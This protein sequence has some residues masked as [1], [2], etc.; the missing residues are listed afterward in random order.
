MRHCTAFLLLLLAFSSSTTFTQEPIRH[1]FL[2]TG[3]TTYIYEEPAAVAAPAAPKE[4]AK[5]DKPDATADRLFDDFERE[6]WAPW[7]AEGTSFGEGPVEI[8]KIPSYQG[9]VNARGKFCVQSHHTRKGEEV[10]EGDAHLG[11]LT[12]PP[13][14]IEFDAIRM[15]VGGGNHK[16][17]TCIELVID[18]KVVAS[19]TGDAKNLMRDRQFDVRKYRGKEARLRVADRVSSGWGNISLDHVVFGALADK[20]AEP[21]AKPLARGEGLVWSFP[22]SS[23]DGWVLSSGN[24]LLALGNSKKYRGGAVVEVTRE[25]EVVFEYVGTQKEIQAVQPLASGRIMCVEGGA[26]PRVLELN[27]HTGKVA[28]EVP[29]QCQKGNIHM[30]T[31][32]ARKLPNGNYLAPHLLDFAVK[33]YDPSG[34]VVKVFATDDQGRDKKSWPFT[35][36]RLDNGNTLVGC[37]YAARVVEFDPAGKIVWQ[38]D[39]SDLDEPLIKDACGVQRLANGNTVVCAYGARG[40]NAV[41]LFEVTPEKKVVWT[42]KSGNNHGV[43]HVQIISTNGKPLA[44]AARSMK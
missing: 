39:N 41:K 40:P 25:G 20:S 34:K 26:N 32:M 15:R 19:M 9:N 42:H 27:R 18:N 30:Q 36:I 23:R 4:T 13:F 7:K 43:H 11:T 6:T 8:K 31:R 24:V 2:A 14:T 17:Q 35:A 33:E 12:S 1:G 21:T 28:L 22:H 37:T 38:L 16:G 5:A 3:S 29:L 44:A 10:R